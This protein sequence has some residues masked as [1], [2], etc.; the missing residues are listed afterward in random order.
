MQAE[1]FEAL[2]AGLEAQGMS[3]GDISRCS[4]VSYATVWRMANGAAQQPSYQTV[5][6]LQ[7]LVVDRSIFPKSYSPMNKKSA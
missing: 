5:E 2:I 4:G 3:K 7:R 1:Q 6:R